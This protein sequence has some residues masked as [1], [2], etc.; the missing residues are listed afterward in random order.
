MGPVQTLQQPILLILVMH[1]M[2]PQTL[3]WPA[4]VQVQVW[5]KT[6][7]Y[8]L[9]IALE[10]QQ[11]NKCDTNF[12]SEQVH[13]IAC[14]VSGTSI[15]G[16]YSDDLLSSFYQSACGEELPA[17]DILLCH[18]KYSKS[19]IRLVHWCTLRFHATLMLMMGTEQTT[20]TLIWKAQHQCSSL[21]K[22]Y[23]MVSVMTWSVCVLCK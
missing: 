22:H 20:R 18:S 16:S 8:H 3:V 5:H 9:R 10:C 7:S 4:W 23:S 21:M 19:V 1:W 15:M 2:S 12:H 6:V 17:I 13:Q 14:E 11:H